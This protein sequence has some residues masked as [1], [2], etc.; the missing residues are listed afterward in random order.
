MGLAW[1]EKIPRRKP[2]Q[3]SQLPPGI[4]SVEVDA[5]VELRNG[6]NDKDT[7]GETKLHRACLDVNKP[8]VLEL[9]AAKADP[10]IKDDKGATALMSL[11]KTP[12]WYHA[13]E[14]R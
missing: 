9:L 11:L 3:S 8:L 14:E 12:T 1:K 10:R 6:I 7:L 13:S 4:K 5:R 2:V